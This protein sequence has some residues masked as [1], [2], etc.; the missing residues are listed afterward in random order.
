MMVCVVLLY[1][2]APPPEL[3]VPLATT[4]WCLGIWSGLGGVEFVSRGGLDV[5]A[6]S[7][8]HVYG[9][10]AVGRKKVRREQW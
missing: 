6:D 7:A 9:A 4:S 2:P 3:L 10:V 8:E 1:S 5:D